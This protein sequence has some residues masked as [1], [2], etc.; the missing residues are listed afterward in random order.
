MQK[1]SEIPDAYRKYMDK[2][3]QEKEERVF[4]INYNYK[5]Y[6]SDNDL[7]ASQNYHHYCIKVCNKIGF[8]LS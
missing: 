5:Q 7:L 8:Y 3:N 4:D 1:S 2:G 6:G